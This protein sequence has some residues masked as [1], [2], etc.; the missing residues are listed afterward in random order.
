MSKQDVRNPQPS[1][2]EST[3][4]ACTSQACCPLQGRWGLLLW[5]ALIGGIVYM[6]WPMLK[7][8][9]YMAA[10]KEAPASGVAWRSGFD[11]ALAESAQTGRP[12]LLDS[13]RRGARRA[14]S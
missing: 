8:A 5:A 9:Y 2:T 6:Q 10:G 3:P 11:A 14:R 7:G 1:S 4:K 12:L 13:P